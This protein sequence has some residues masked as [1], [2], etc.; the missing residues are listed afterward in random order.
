MLARAFGRGPALRPRPRSRFEPMPSGPPDDA[1]L[2]EAPDAALP[3]AAE[4]ADMAGPVISPHDPQPIPRTAQGPAPEP[5][6]GP[7]PPRAAAPAPLTAPT[8]LTAAVARPAAGPAPPAIKQHPTNPLLSGEPA[9][10]DRRTARLADVGSATA[11]TP[12]RPMA[13]PPSAAPTRSSTALPADRTGPEARPREGAALSELDSP[14]APRRTEPPWTGAPVPGPSPQPAPAEPAAVS[15]TRVRPS[16]SVARRSA[17]PTSAP[18]PDP[19]R[20]LSD[21]AVLAEPPTATALVPAEPRTATDSSGETRPLAGTGRRDGAPPL[22]V[23]RPAQA[24]PFTHTDQ[25]EVTDLPS[26]PFAA[27][28]PVVATASMSTRR[29][30]SSRPDNPPAPVVNVTIG[31]VEVRQPPAPP[32]PPPAPAPRAR[33]LSLDEYLER[34]NRSLP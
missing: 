31:R 23:G 24:R 10:D 22:A 9:A 26:G 19:S 15:A 1:I 13:R 32:A 12:S 3:V 4:P 7:D 18:N 30:P 20:V 8:P 11:R 6:P 33:P 2:P 21:S 29:R 16:R 28:D 17:S 25:A 27:P 14:D 5:G 34:R